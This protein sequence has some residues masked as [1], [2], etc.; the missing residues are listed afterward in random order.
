MSKSYKTHRIKI[1]KMSINLR[2]T[3][4]SVSTKTTYQRD[5]IL[6]LQFV[7]YVLFKVKYRKYHVL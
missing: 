5:A 4:N 7:Q 3:R 1:I 2:I 6:Q